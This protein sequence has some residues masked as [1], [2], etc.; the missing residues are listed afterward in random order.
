MLG[1]PTHFVG[2]STM[3][4]SQIFHALGMAKLVRER[5][6]GKIPIVWG[7]P[8]PSSVPEQFIE[9]PYVDLVCVGE[10]D[11]TFSEIVEA[12]EQ[13]RAFA[14]VQGIVFKQGHDIVET[15][16]R[17]LIDVET[18]L[19]TPWE[20]LEIEK[21]IHRDF[22]VKNTLRSL[23]IGQTSRGCPYD[24]GFCSSA[25]LRKRKWRPM[26]AEKSLAL[27]LDP[28]RRFQLDGI[29][30]RDDEFYINKDRV[31]QIVKGILDSETKIR[32]YTSG[33]RVDVFN[34]SSDEFLRFLKKSGA[35]SL[36]FGAESGTNRM[37]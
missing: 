8:H 9:H 33:T 19:P 35:D 25:A 3:I 10:G 34:K 4:G 2:I 29:W 28:V 20:L 21:Y 24:C 37:L 14:G 30:I 22:Y 26:S 11:L 18:L 15:P 36:K 32:W 31:F 1:S 16:E 5:T 27:I 13:K 6:D 23:D 17:P 12:Y 7:G